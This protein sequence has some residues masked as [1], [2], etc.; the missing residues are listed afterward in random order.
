MT[1]RNKG[2]LL[3]IRF[4]DM[5]ALY[6]IVLYINEWFAVNSPDMEP[7]RH[8]LFDRGFELLKPPISER[9][10][11]ILLT[12][13]VVYFMIRWYSTERKLLANYLLLVTILFF[14]R[15]FVFMGTETPTPQRRC[16]AITTDHW[17]GTHYRWLFGETDDTCIDNMFS[18]HAAHM[19]G[20]LLFTLAFSKYLSEKVGVCLLTAALLIS[21]VWSR[22]HYTSDVMVGVLLTIGYFFAVHGTNPSLFARAHR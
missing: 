2:F 4:A 7:Y 19:V 17:K 8:P 16:K 10:P 21:L 22:L 20:I 18:G 14:M 13:G 15:I 5:L 12:I 11:D 1:V 3:D 6:V 9:I